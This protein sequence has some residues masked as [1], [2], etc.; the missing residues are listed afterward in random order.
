MLHPVCRISR[1]RS[2]RDISNYSF[3]T[4]IYS[5][6]LPNMGLDR[7]KFHYFTLPTDTPSYKWSIMY[8]KGLHRGVTSRP[9][10]NDLQ[11]SSTI[12]YLFTSVA[13]LLDL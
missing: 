4:N 11:S 1:Y 6:L 10:Q 3:V 9:K 12:N 7:T 13:S 2:Q 5:S 8:K